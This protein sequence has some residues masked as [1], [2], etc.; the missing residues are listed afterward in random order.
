MLFV[1][2]EWHHEL[3]NKK[4]HRLLSTNNLTNKNPRPK[5]G[6]IYSKRRITLR[7]ALSALLSA[8]TGLRRLLILLVR[9]LLATALLAAALAAL[10]VLLPALV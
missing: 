1:A 2:T 3:W 9:L 7:A 4:I 6:V 5:P 8:L 10:L